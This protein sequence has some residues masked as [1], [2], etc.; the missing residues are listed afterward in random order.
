MNDLSF[1][2]DFVII[3]GAAIGINF[4]FHRLH[5]AP[6]VGYLIAGVLLG[7]SVLG[8]TQD[9]ALIE[10]LAQVGVIL[11]LFL[12]GIEFS[13]AELIRINRAVFVGGFLQVY[14]TTAAVLLISI[15]AGISIEKG[16]FVG[17]LVAMSS[18]AIVF[19][20]LS[21]RGEMDSP[22]GRLSSGI[23]IFQDLSVVA[24]VLFLPMLGGKSGFSAFDV[25]L[26]VFWALSIVVLMI[27][28]SRF[29][30]PKMLY[31][32]VSTH[33]REL[34]L[35]S[36]V[37]I[38]FGT[39]WLTSLVGLSLALG[40]FLA[41]LVISE[42]EY[43]HQAFSEILPLKDIFSILFFVSIGMLLDVDSM[44]R[45]PLIVLLAVALIL[46]IK[47]AAGTLVTIVLGY[48][49]RIGVL[50]GV[51]LSQIGE[52]SFVL[53]KEGINLGLFSGSDY[54]VFLASSIITMIF[55]PFMIQGSGR[56]SDYFERLPISRKI[57][58]GRFQEDVFEKQELTN[59]V[60]VVGFGLNGRNVTKVLSASAIP[61]IVLEINPETVRV[62]KKRG[63]P[64]SYGDASK[65]TMLT[66]LGINTAR[67]VVIA[68]S[69][70]SATR[71]IVELSRKL[72]PNIYIIARTRYTSEV[73]P[74]YSL[75]A[76]DVIPEEFETS[77][78]IISRVLHNY[79]IPANEIEKHISEVRKGG[80]EI[81]RNVA[82]KYDVFPELKQH[83]PY[84]EIE[85]IRIEARSPLAGK[86]LADIGFR[87]KYG[88]TVLAIQRGAQT[89]TNPSGETQLL[90][91]DIV[92][93]IGTR[94]CI[95][96]VKSVVL[97]DVRE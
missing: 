62:E 91:Q 94:E 38:C 97:S 93:L 51:A 17:I 80:Y 27:A 43:G 42:S 34:F 15:S 1:L 31:Q 59:H 63:I 14:L 61:F 71:R 24:V 10:V 65:E 79:F 75:G 73:N 88:V 57:K 16:I 56:F 78:E 4:L 81:F 32:V 55:T 41:G 21:D 85:T 48:P 87:K 70:A 7:P 18:T 64:I 12:I 25:A 35:I 36:I 22:Q 2:K 20:V 53:S 6:I 82:Q 90:A 58:S 28:V 9:I 46:I 19:K 74:L 11:L 26:N 60:I 8:V 66:H 86:S 3:F 23:L 5:I 52:F 89:I 92:I 39:A 44:L 68:I 67:S 96:G 45:N 76:N 49:L 40:A 30:I 95:A 83:L 84:I 33:N 77:I 47:F 54:Q 29:I 37:L 69:D 72:N 50:V 13:L